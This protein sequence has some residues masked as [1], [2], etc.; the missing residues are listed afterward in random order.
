MGASQYSTRSSYGRRGRTVCILLF[1][2]VYPALLQNQRIYLALS[3][4][5]HPHHEA[6]PPQ[7][8]P[9]LAEQLLKDVLDSAVVCQ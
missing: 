5:H 1:G 4:V 3:H 6:F 9:A 2:S 7:A 8:A